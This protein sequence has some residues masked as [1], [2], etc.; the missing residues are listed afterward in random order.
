MDRERAYISCKTSGCTLGIDV[1]L[2]R[3]IHSGQVLHVQRFCLLP[4]SAFLCTLDSVPTT[5]ESGLKV[6]Q[7][8]WSLFKIL[9]DGSD[10]IV[11]AIK[12][13][14]GRKNKSHVEEGDEEEED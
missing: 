12:S 10:N 6:S 2:F 4:S 14:N 11:K 1:V 5:V 3:A 13:L 8:D 9:K 7:Q